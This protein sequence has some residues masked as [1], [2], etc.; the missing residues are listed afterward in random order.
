MSVLD[1]RVPVDDLRR[2]SEELREVNRRLDLLE[3]PSGTQRAQAVKTLIETAIE[4]ATIYRLDA[5]AAIAA[6]AG[7]FATVSTPVPAGYTRALVS[8]TA[9]TTLRSNEAAGGWALLMCAAMIT[10]GGSSFNQ[11]TSVGGQ[12][13]GSA[14]AASAAVLEDLAPGSSVNVAA[15]VSFA[16]AYTLGRASVAGS[17]LFLR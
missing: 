4:P 14:S 10:G 8:L 2:L 9:S 16:G 6:T 11:W 12:E 3:A 13:Y 15:R 1:P 17:I 7:D 5:G